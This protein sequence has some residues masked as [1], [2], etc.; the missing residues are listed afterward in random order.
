MRN[1]PGG[2]RTISSFGG[3]VAR[4]AAAFLPSG[5]HSGTTS[6]TSLP[7]LVTARTPVAKVLKA[8]TVKTLSFAVRR[9]W[10]FMRVHLYLIGMSHLKIRCVAFRAAAARDWA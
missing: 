10:T 2:T 5:V 1:G 7:P 3:K 8:K 9:L 6:A 4:C